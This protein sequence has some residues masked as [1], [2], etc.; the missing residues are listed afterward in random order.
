MKKKR[1]NKLHSFALK[2]SVTHPFSIFINIH[3]FLLFFS[4]KG[5]E[6]M[7]K[8]GGK[9]SVYKKGISMYIFLK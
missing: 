8:I 9:G 6:Y 7:V 4:N 1:K 2:F 3:S 5:I